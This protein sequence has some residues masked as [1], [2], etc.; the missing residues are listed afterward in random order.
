MAADKL[1][2]RNV[3]KD[4]KLKKTDKV[5]SAG[6]PVYINTK[7]GEEHSEISITLEMPE[8][9]GNWI[10]VPSLI[11]GRVYNVQ[12]VID[13]LK[14]GEITPNSTGHATQ[15][16]AVE[17]AIY[18][19]NNLQSNIGQTLKPANDE[20][21]LAQ[22]GISTDSNGIRRD[23]IGRIIEYQPSGP[24]VGEPTPVVVDDMGAAMSDQMNQELAST[25]PTEEENPDGLFVVNDNN[26]DAVMTYADGRAYNGAV[27]MINGQPADAA[28]QKLV[29]NDASTVPVDDTNKAMLAKA[30]EERE[31]RE[32]RK[33][34][35]E[36]TDRL[37]AIM[38]RAN[39][40]KDD[41][42][43]Y[44]PDDPDLNTPWKNWSAKYRMEDILRGTGLKGA[45]NPTMNRFIQ[46]PPSAQDQAIFDQARSKRKLQ[47]T[48]DSSGLDNE[49]FDIPIFGNDIV[50]DGS[51]KSTTKKATTKKSTTKKS[52]YDSSN[53]TTKDNESFDIP[54]LGN[55]TVTLPTNV[56]PDYG[57]MP[58][59]KLPPKDAKGNST[60]NYW[61]VDETSPFWQTDAGYE[62]AI[63]VWG[64][65][66]GWVK[67]NYRPKK[68]EL[69]IN[70]IK[71]WFTP[72]K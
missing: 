11:N 24:H 44:N 58:G 1:H 21:A 65:K 68:K 31:L 39:A 14:A 32:S 26:K 70:A 22:R 34:S 52:K 47:R 8:G 18:R 2:L 35:K 60:G 15:D 72:S 64:E 43:F 27:Q 48:G 42:Y 38:D 9:S 53:Q 40:E 19:S 54:I 69:D 50:T 36:Q 51:K 30:A 6:R 4:Y 13:M 46:S 67:P 62:K 57:D 23:A 41:S 33:R 16:A 45:E 3:N 61:S 10:N 20:I 59:F 37:A 55:D 63:Q 71:K 7:T 5:T 17:A 12:G 66:P 29:V 56:K 49:A 25:Y 28:G